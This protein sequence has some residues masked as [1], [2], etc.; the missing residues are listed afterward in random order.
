MRARL[1]D[2]VVAAMDHE[3]VEQERLRDTADFAEGIRAMA[4]RRQP[5]FEGR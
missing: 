5:N 4:E 3:A 2:D 1:V